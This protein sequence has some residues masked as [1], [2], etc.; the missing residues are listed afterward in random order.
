MDEFDPYH[1]WLGIPRSEQ[2]PNH[3]RLLGVTLFESD[4]DV[5][6]AAADRQMTYVS[7]CATGAHLKLS[8][9]LL[10][11]LSSARVCLLVPAKR[12]AY[13]AQLKAKFDQARR[14]EESLVPAPLGELDDRFPS[15]GDIVRPIP[16]FSNERPKRR[17]NGTA[18]SPPK[19]MRVVSG[20]AC[21][22]VLVIVLGVWSLIGGRPV[23]SDGKLDPQPNGSNTAAVKPIPAETSQA[24]ASNKPTKPAPQPIPPA[25][26]IPRDITGDD[27]PLVILDAQYGARDKWTDLTDRLRLASQSGV[28]GV[29]VDSALVGAD[30]LPG[31][32][33]QLVLRYRLKGRQHEHVVPDFHSVVVIDT[34]PS[35]PQDPS[36]GEGLSI[37]EARYGGN[38]LGEGEWIDL[39]NRLRE[40]VQD[41]RLRASVSDIV[42]GL[43][44]RRILIVRWSIHGQT[45]TSP[46]EAGDTIVLGSDVPAV[47]KLDAH[48]KQAPPNDESLAILEARFGTGDKWLDLT[49][50]ISAA[51]KPGFVACMANTTT[52]IDDPA[53]NSGKTFRV[54]YQLGGFL[55]D[56]IYH[57]GSFVYL[58]GRSN[59]PPIPQSGLTILHA[60]CGHGVSGEVRNGPPRMI[61][62]SE[63]L[64]SQVRD[65]RLVLSVRS[66]FPGVPG[67]KWLL[68]RYALDGEIRLAVFDE[69]SEVQLGGGSGSALK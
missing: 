65:N 48:R 8:Q 68:V 19:S 56:Q 61:E 37:H 20:A 66:A 52:S 36:S 47:A 55:H 10:N 69:R 28:L 1:K 39:T 57:E 9:Q 45:W 15:N 4:P 67:P 58:D 16:S 46:F 26:T 25:T 35:P 33:K 23:K 21:G 31:V 49:D 22:G 44:S 54:R 2:P 41:G 13:D 18:K 59:Q 53:P 62:V 40:K 38:I 27:A 60:I 14:V 51:A 30:P 64:Q 7:Q 29:V 34:R 42:S 32:S 17:R 12:H 11:E 63:H 6:E 5:I 43:P 3:Y 24:V 50:R